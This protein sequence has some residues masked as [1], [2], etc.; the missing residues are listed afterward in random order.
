MRFIPFHVNLTTTFRG[1]SKRS[2]VLIEGTDEAGA[3]HWGEY[4]PFPDYNAERSSR[5]WRAAMEAATGAWPEPIRQTV[6]VNAIVPL[7]PPQD[8]ARYATA[9]GCRTAK[10][11]VGGPGT[12]L[13]DDIARVE[14]A[15]AALAAGGTDGKIRIDANGSWDVDEAVIAIN[16]LDRAAQ[17]GGLAGLEYVEQ[18][19]SEVADLAVV[20]RRINVPVAAD[21]SVRIPGDVS[22]VLAA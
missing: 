7:V 19:C 2:G 6:P 5:W 13:R 15:A 10:V 1:V 8:V 16:E 18:P 9:H 3:T 14:A 20:R 22:A 4:S 21:E 17:T 11:K 12:C